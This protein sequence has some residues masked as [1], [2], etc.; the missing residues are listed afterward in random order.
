MLIPPL[1]Q[2]FEK[3]R[4]DRR[5]VAC[6]LTFGL[7]TPYMFLPFG[8]GR[9]YLNEVLIGNLNSN[10]LAVSASLAPKAMRW[11]WWRDC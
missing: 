9:I 11:E 2:V 1:L 4:L 10:G 5:A 3:I 7:I 6:I 8:F